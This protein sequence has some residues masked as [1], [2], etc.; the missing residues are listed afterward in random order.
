MDF[1]GDAGLAMSCSR[2]ILDFLEDKDER[3]IHT[4]TNVIHEVKGEIVFENV[5]FKYPERDLP[6]LKNVS[7][8]IPAYSKVAFVGASGSGK[9]S[10]L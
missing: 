6:V 3:Q 4:S 5:S 2:R 1:M 10:I 8:R 7:F 9:S